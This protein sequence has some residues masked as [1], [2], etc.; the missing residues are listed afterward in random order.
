MRKRLRILLESLG[1]PDA[2]LSVS[3]VGDSFM[4]T[5]NRTYR[6]IDRPTDVL[7][8]SMQE[9]AFPRIQPDVLGDIVIA[10]PV[11][12]RQASAAGHDL[13][14]EIDLLL[15]HGLLH[16]LGYDHERGRREDISMKRKERA[17]LARLSA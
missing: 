7:S 8:F 2:E 1:L 17:L 13:H 12:A 15:I 16:L 14:C 10:V 5:L 9:G 4:R 6:R 11:A 3:F